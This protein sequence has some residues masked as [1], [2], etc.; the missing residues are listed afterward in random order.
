MKRMNGTIAAVV[1]AAVLLTAGSALAWGGRGGKATG[2]Q[3]GMMN[4]QNAQTQFQPGQRMMNP[5]MNPR[6][7]GPMA[8]RQMMGRRGNF[9][10]NCP[11]GSRQMMGRMGNF[12]N[13][14]RMGMWASV[15]IPQEIKDKQTEMGKLS[16]EMRNEMG[17]KPI[18]RTKIEE[19]YK[20]RV[21]L[22]NELS[23]WRFQ[24]KLNMIEKLQK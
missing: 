11:A 24:Q 1:C 9:G 21:E 6:M 22:R 3:Q 4:Q 12:A 7:A 20:K 14:G 5:G 2:G 13:S 23:G 15:E 19:L 17:K 18:D 8:N 10:N 16:L